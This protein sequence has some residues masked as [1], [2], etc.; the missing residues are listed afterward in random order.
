MS[1]YKTIL[2]DGK[3]KSDVCINKLSQSY[4]YIPNFQE[5]SGKTIL[6]LFQIEEIV[7]NKAKKTVSQTNANILR[8]N[9]II[10]KRLKNIRRIDDM[11]NYTL[12]F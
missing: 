8:M 7:G 12:K 2:L 5:V 1:Q 10:E 11:T 9:R 6:I 4:T 3:Q